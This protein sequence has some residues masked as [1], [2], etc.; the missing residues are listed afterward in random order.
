MSLLDD[1]VTLF[2]VAYEKYC[3]NFCSKEVLRCYVISFLTFQSL[4]F[5]FLKAVFTA[6]SADWF[7]GNLL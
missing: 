7:V 2:M 5:C 3:L 1:L 6:K 4:S